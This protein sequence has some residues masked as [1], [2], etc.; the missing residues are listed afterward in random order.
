MKIKN[1]SVIGAPRLR[2]CVKKKSAK[3]VG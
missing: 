1:E 3:D 2:P